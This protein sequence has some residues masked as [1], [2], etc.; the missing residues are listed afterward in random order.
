MIVA[1][2][3]P[4]RPYILHG[5]VVFGLLLKRPFNRLVIKRIKNEIA[6]PLVLKLERTG[7]P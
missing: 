2:T 5:L 3:L 6:N 4:I 7:R 1:P